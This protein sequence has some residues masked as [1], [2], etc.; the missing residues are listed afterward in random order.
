MKKDKNTCLTK[1]EQENR[2]AD[3]VAR[4]MFI[5]RVFGK[6]RAS[7]AAAGYIIGK[8]SVDKHQKRY[9]KD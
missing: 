3:N 6:D 9:C 4:G 7:G 8:R 2:I 1:Q 5:A